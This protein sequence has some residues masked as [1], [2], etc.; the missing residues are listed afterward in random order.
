MDHG[1]TKEWLDRYVAAWISYDPKAIGDLFTDD[2]SYRYHPSDE[3][4]VGR[5]AVVASWLGESPSD[6]VSTRDAP[7]TYAAAYEPI[8]VDGDVVVATGF[9]FWFLVARANLHGFENIIAARGGL[10]SPMRARFTRLGLVPARQG[11]DLRLPW[12]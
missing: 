3:P 8:A 7:G 10:A 12:R 6:D 11:R 4:T 2:V 1:T 5:D 9:R